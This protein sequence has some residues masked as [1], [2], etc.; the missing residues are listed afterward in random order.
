[1]KDKIDTVVGLVRNCSFSRPGTGCILAYLKGKSAE[2]LFLHLNG[3][4]EKIIDRIIAFH[5]ECPF[6]DRLPI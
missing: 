3:L 4:G 5:Q 2:E 6:S 1:M